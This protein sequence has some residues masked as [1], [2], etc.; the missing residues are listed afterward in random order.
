MKPIHLAVEGLLDAVVA[1]RLAEVC[2]LD[3]LPAN[4]KGGKGN[5]DKL[6]TAYNNAAKGSPWLV[7]RDL[8]RDAECAGALREKLIL[9]PQEWMCFRIPVRAI[10]SWL[11]ADR[12]RF[13]AFARIRITE[14]P[15]DP[16]A[17]SYPKRALLDLVSQSRSNE[18]RKSIVPREGSG[19]REGPLYTSVLSEFALKHWRPT[20]A[21]ANSESLRRCLLQLRRTSARWKQYLGS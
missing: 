12:E 4:V 9:A 19:G 7:L 14:I 3:P 16:D 2:G 20:R 18:L 10:E 5:L 1:S 8:D 13:A 6:L 21:A 15:A 11:L 17:L